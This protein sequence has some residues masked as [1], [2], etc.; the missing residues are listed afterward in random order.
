MSRFDRQLQILRVVVLAIDDQQILAP[1]G[2]ETPSE[3]K[4]RSPVRRNCRLSLPTVAWKVSAV[5]CS[6]PR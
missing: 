4:P 1:A 2:D 5:A 6:S 3:R